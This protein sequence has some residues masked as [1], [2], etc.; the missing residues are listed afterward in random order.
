MMRGENSMTALRVIAGL[1]AGFVFG[2]VLAA[3]PSSISTTAVGVLASV[4]TVFVSL[5]KMTVMPLLVSL[6]VASVGGMASPGGLGRI[7]VRALAFSVILLLLASVGSVLLAEPVL[8]RVSIDQTAAMALRGGDAG[9]TAPSAPGGG[10]S[11]GQWIVDLIPQ[12]V[13]KSASDGAMLPVILFSVLFGLALARAKEPDRN[14]MLGAA[15]GAADAMQRLVGWILALAP[16]GVFALAVPLAARLGWAALGAVAAYIALVVGITVLAAAVLLYPVGIVLGGMSLRRFIG[17][18][19]PAQ[20]I[21][22]AAR[23]SLAALPAAVE[24]AERERMSGTTV[25]LLLPLGIAIFHFG[26]AVAQTVGVLFL[27]RL[28]GVA[29]SPTAIALVVLAVLFATFAVPGVPGGSIIAMVPVLATAHL[30][31]EGIGILLAVDAVPD[32]F[33]TTA[34][35]TG[36][37]TLAAVLRT[38]DPEAEP[39]SAR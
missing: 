5:I 20:A 15:R 34:N 12:N 4:G 27:A 19:A 25:R 18:C 38:P 6:L 14:L 22:F 13:V 23:S 31:V 35:L 2:L 39:T 29:L 7:G 21:A 1:V 26:A 3:N 16:V 9:A 17:Y 11:L 37:M 32:M 10:T 24:S 33:R 28:Y 8:S 36:A 30:P